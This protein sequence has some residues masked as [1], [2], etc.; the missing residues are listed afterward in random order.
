MADP[1][2]VGGVLVVDDPVTNLDV[3]PDDV[4]FV[5]AEIAAAETAS[6]LAG[7]AGRK[8]K[9]HEIIVTNS[10]TDTLSDVTVKGAASTPG[11][12]H[13]AAPGG[14]GWRTSG[15][16]TVFETA[17]GEGLSVISSAAASVNVSLWYSLKP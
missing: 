3:D 10:D 12:K 6:L 2:R 13:A 15:I 16:R 7:V 8:I 1:K 9:V 14:G 5:A 11:P 4:L 17:Y